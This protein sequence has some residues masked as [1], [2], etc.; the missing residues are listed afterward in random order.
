M[1]LG[2]FLD[3]RDWGFFAG[4]NC[5]SAGNGIEL[6]FQRFDLLFDGEDL[7]ELGCR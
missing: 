7:A 4:W 1:L 5:T 6:A 3:G 2:G